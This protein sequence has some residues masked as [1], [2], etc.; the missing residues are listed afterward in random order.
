[1]RDSDKNMSLLF[2]DHATMIVSA[3]PVDTEYK[4]INSFYQISALQ[5]MI[6]IA[7]YSLLHSNSNLYR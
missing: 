1:M 6:V 2:R 5:W 3:L 7:Q 4:Y